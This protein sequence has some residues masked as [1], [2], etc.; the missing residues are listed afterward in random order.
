MTTQEVWRGYLLEEALAWLLRNSGY[1][2]LVDENDDPEALS[3][4]SNG[5]RVKGRGAYHQVDV[6]GEFEFT[7]AFSLPIRL[8]LEAKFYSRERCGLQTVRNAHGVIDDVNENFVRD[9]SRKQP[10]RKRYRYV[11]AL[12]SASGFTADAQ[13]YALAQQISIVDLSGASF[14]WLRDSVTTAAAVLGK[15]PTRRRGNVSPINWMRTRLREMLQTS[16]NRG[17]DEAPDYR[18]NGAFIAQTK[19]PLFEEAAEAALSGLAADLRSHQ[20]SELLLGFLST[21]F[22]VPMA[23]EDADRFL[24]FVQTYPEHEIRLGRTGFGRGTEWVVWPAGHSR[25]YRLTFKLPERLERWIAENEEQRAGRVWTI[26][27]RFLSSVVI[28]RMDGSDLQ[29]YQL[30]YERGDLDRNRNDRWL[31]DG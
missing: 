10:P 21:P 7:P 2:L 19:A 17:A 23:A 25:D 26:E 5:L 4:G 1:R 8:F 15:V 12:F 3:M 29:T 20:R 22:I 13:D 18:E 27:Q 11:Y 6:L 16:L 9:G 14:T 24:R 30:R 28:Y 31:P